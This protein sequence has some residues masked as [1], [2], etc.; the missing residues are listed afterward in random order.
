MTALAIQSAKQHST[1]D[2]LLGSA[3][4]ALGAIDK[5]LYLKLP[6]TTEFAQVDPKKYNAPDPAQLFAT[7][8]GITSLMTATTNPV[9]GKK[10]REGADV[11]KTFTGTLPG[12]RVVKLL[13]IGDAAKTF[14]VTYGI[15]D[16]GGELR[17]VTMVGPFYQGAT[18]TY[19]LTLDKYGA[20]VE[21]SKP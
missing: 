13:N 9:E 12:D 19:V 1:T 10:S 4:P 21:I 17:S 11:L 6:F 7:E 16:P 2:R 3:M 14:E 18:S 8:G 5:L 15:T 20:P